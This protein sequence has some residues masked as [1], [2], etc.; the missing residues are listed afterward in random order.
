MPWVMTTRRLRVS[1][2]FGNAVVW[3]IVI[4]AIALFAEATLVGSHHKDGWWPD[5]FGTHPWL[6]VPSATSIL[7][8]ALG[9]VA[10][11]SQFRLGL[12]PMLVHSVLRASDAKDV[13]IDAELDDVR[14]VCLRNN[15]LGPAV[16][17]SVHYLITSTREQIPGVTMHTPDPLQPSPVSRHAVDYQGLVAALEV[18]HL[19]H[20]KDLRIGRLGK[21]ATIGRDGELPLMELGPEVWDRM[22]QLTFWIIYRGVLGP[23]Y[24]KQAMIVP[25]DRTRAPMADEVIHLRDVEPS[26]SD[27][28][29][30]RAE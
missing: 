3:S 12:R 19:A 6:E 24:R 2:W 20:N 21:G 10:V 16:I 14:L 23:A 7:V 4:G 9:L 18:L 13:T 29:P 17:H 25:P 8:G 15:G 1:E 26:L 27:V 28:E 22:S 30:S 5:A 11:R